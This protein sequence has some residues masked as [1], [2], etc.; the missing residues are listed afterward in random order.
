MADSIRARKLGFVR[1]TRIPRL[2]ARRKDANKGDFGRVL[3]IGGSVGMPGAPALAGMAALRTGAGLVTMAV[4]ISIQPIVATLCPCATTIGLPE[5]AG[6]QID[7]V[8][9][10]GM[11]SE[12]G[13]CGSSASSPP[14]ALVVG[15][16]LG[17][18]DAS[19]GRSV[20]E[21]ID[22]F[23]IAAS[24]PAVIDADAL[25]L[26]HKADKSAPEV[27]NRRPHPRTI[28][29][30]HPGEMARLVGAPI[31]EVQT[32]REAVAG[33]TARMMADNVPDDIRPVVVLKGAGTIV[34]DNRRIYVNRTGNPGMATGGSGDVL[35]GV[36]GALIGQKLSLFD[37]AVLGT[38]VHGRAG[39]LA[40]RQKGLLSLIAT[41]L[42]DSLP[43][44]L[45]ESSSIR[46]RR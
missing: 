25:N 43:A 30:P 12:R 44:A 14:D 28:I 32:H 27:W 29:T 39:D 46:S 17:R 22:A 26:A 7:P 21:L 45:R 41:D 18:G 9:A 40:A 38:Y 1:I 3:V 20:W 2:P 13:L 4:P 16:G 15:M 36:I 34:T 24:V 42:C 8:L 37:A 35:A 6:G 23:R 11:L 31:T 5:T 10:L 19:Y 33:Q